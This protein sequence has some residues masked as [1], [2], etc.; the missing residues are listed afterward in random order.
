MVLSLT[1]PDEYPYVIV[2]TTIVPFVANMLMG[3]P[4]MKARKRL[5][6]PY[7]NAYA[8]PGYHKHADEFNRV[9]R[10]HQNM[11]ETMPNMIVMALVGGIKYPITSAVC[12]L[13]YS[14]GSWLYLI[15]YSDTSLDVKTARYKKGGAV[16]MLGLLGTF[17]T[18]CGTCWALL[19]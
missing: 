10:G 2:S 1:L 14:A 16:K 6:V 19:R 7:P 9:Q 17:F 4:V 5:E 13:A 15:G 18:C 3:G 12:A 8:T 11:F